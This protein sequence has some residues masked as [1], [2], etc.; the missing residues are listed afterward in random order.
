MYHKFSFYLLIDSTKQSKHK[1][2]KKKIITENKY[3]LNI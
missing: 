2:I 3:I 1:F